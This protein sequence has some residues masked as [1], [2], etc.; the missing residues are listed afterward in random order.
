MAANLDRAETSLTAVSDIAYIRG[1]DG[2]GNSV[3][4]SKADLAS[5][6]GDNYLG[7]SYGKQKIDNNTDLNLDSY[8]TPGAYRIDN[9][10]TITGTGY[11]DGSFY[12]SLFVIKGYQGDVLQIITK[13]TGSV[14]YVRFFWSNSPTWR[15]VKIQSV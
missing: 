2:S 15:T 7:Q 9:P 1:I 14:C 11:A 3:R 12:G 6:L 4:I 10:R 8:K 5:V 13:M